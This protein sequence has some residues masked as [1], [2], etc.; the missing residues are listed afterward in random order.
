MRR[1]HEDIERCH[2]AGGIGQE[3]RQFHSLT[4]TEFA[5]ARLEVLFQ[6]A[7]SDD[8]QS[9]PGHP[10][11]GAGEGV[12]QFAMRL[13]GHQAPDGAEDKGVGCDAEGLAG[14]AAGESCLVQC[15][16]IDGV[17][18]R[19]AT[20]FRDER[21]GLEDI[22]PDRLRNPDELETRVQAFPYK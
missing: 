2:V 4:Q 7:A 13:E 16:G 6:F 14:L 8:D 20:L 18:D 17:V 22:A 9:R 21:H 15:P 10:L 5:D 19:K 1:Q 3:A 11:R 12:D